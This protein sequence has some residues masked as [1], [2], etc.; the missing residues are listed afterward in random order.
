MKYKNLPPRKAFTL[1]ELLVVIAIIAVLIGLLVPAVQKVRD[2]AKRTE[3]QNN[4]K[5]I[6]LALHGYHDTK[7]YFPANHRLSATNSVRERWFTKVLPWL[8]QNNIFK[9]YDETTNW[10]S[11]ANLPYTSLPLK[12]AICP[13]TPNSSRLDGNPAL[14]GG[15]ANIASTVAV[16]DYGAIYGLHPTFL[17]ANGITQPN[18]EG[19]LTK[20]DGQFVSIADVTDGLS[21]TLAV[22]ESAGR[23]FLYNQGGTR[24]NANYGINGVNGG[25]WSRPASDLWIIGSDKTGTVVGGSYT[26][27]VANGFDHGG[28]YPLQIGTPALGTDPSGAIFSFHASGAHGLLADGSVRFL[29]QSLPANVISALVTRAGGEN[30]PKY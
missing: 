26:V 14:G 18:P 5:Q 11:P 1:I 4:L 9:N 24:A 17:T 29:D 6:G 25:G 2:A 15:W 27:N 3:C 20:T 10:D 23:P 22:A 13:A 8:E 12:V 19:I 7:G 21:N 28:Q 30:V 16:T